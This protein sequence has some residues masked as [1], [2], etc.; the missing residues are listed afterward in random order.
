MRAHGD[1][2][3]EEIVKMEWRRWNEDGQMIGK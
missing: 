2:F 1:G 3:D